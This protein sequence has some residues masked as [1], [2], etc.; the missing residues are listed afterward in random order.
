MY[1]FSCT[2][3][4]F[5]CSF[6]WFLL[7]LSIYSEVIFQ[8]PMYYFWEPNGGLILVVWNWIKF[9]LIIKILK[10]IQICLSVQQSTACKQVVT[11]PNVPSNQRTLRQWLQPNSKHKHMLRPGKVSIRGVWQIQPITFFLCILFFSELYYNVHTFK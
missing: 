1:I 10:M 7:L 4:S 5:V 2:I 3:S 6:S 9:G 11:Q 8:T